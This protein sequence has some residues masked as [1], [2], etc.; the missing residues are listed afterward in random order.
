M[1]PLVSG[2]ELRRCDLGPEL[3]SE[4][5]SEADEQREREIVDCR[6]YRER[7]ALVESDYIPAILVFF[8]EA[9]DRLR[10][11]VSPTHCECPAPSAR[12]AVEDHDPHLVRVSRD[13]EIVRGAGGV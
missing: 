10:E 5:C 9:D 2:D 4:S 1:A 12:D 13:L 7:V 6:G 11:A 8:K 3:R